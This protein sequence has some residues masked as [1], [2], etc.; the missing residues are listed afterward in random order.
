MMAM[1]PLDAA[2]R[3]KNGPCEDDGPTHNHDPCG[4]APPK[5]M[6]LLSVILSKFH[7]PHSFS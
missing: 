1:P 3:L 7:N 5:K 2:L 6:I 4:S